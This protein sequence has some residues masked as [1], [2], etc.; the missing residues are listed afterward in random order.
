MRNE[1]QAG[2]LFRGLD[3]RIEL[4]RGLASGSAAFHGWCR[5]LFVYHEMSARK[6]LH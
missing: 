1:R 6:P 2:V 4:N 5:D 3:G